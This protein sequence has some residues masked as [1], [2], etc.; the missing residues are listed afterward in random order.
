MLRIEFG[1]RIA[2]FRVGARGR[3]PGEN[4]VVGEKKTGAFPE[5]QRLLERVPGGLPSRPTGADIGNDDLDV[6]LAVAVQL[7]EPVG[8]QDSAVGPHE[9]VA[10]LCN[11]CR[12][13]LVVTFAA[14]DQWSAKVE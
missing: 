5:L 10:V 11:P 3:V 4:P 2:C 13:R 8:A 14:A 9:L 12:D 7:F 6:M 1:E